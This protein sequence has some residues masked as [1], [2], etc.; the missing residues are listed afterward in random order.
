KRAL[1]IREKVSGTDHLDTAG[2]LQR[3][4]S[5]YEEQGRYAEAEPII[6]RALAILET[7]FGQN[8][9]RRT[10][11]ALDTYAPVLRKLGL[12]N[13]AVVIEAKAKTIREK[14][15]F[16]PTQQISP[17]QSAI[18]NQTVDP[19]QVDPATVNSPNVNPA[20]VNPANGTTIPPS[21]PAGRID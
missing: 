18:P 13:E 5:L 19:S 2:D 15:R 8:N 3:L 12:Q 21:I 1:A 16:P 11:Q 9:P 7:E 10:L 17:N 14:N 20:N 6:N 4:S